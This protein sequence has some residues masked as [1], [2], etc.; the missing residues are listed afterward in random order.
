MDRGGDPQP[1]LLATLACDARVG[2]AILRAPMSSV[3]WIP[4]GLQASITVLAS[5]LCLAAAT[6]TVSEASGKSRLPCD[7]QAA[8]TVIAR[9][10]RVAPKIDGVLEEAVWSQA[11]VSER[12]ADLVSGDRTRL[13]TRVRLLWDDTHL[14]VG[15]TVEEPK[16]R[17][18]MTRHNDPIYYENDV[19][20]FIAGDNAYYEFEINARNT[21]YEVF[22][23]WES[24]YQSS[25][26]AARPEFAR[27]NLQPFNGVGF[28]T[29]PRGPRLGHFDWRFPGLRTAVHVDGTLNDDSDTDRGWSVEIALPWSGIRALFPEGKR[30]IPPRDGDLWAMDFSRFN[31]TKAPAPAKDSGGWAL[32]PHGVWDSHIPECFA[33]VRFVTSTAKPASPAKSGEK[34][35]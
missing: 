3:F 7:P 8:K 9:P 18:Q 10:T 22:F 34:R 15:Y 4:A 12:F 28:T 1:A 30:T 33:Q 29:H 31:T 11:V 14:Y 17:A 20:L 13:D 19:E 25:G 21:V 23:I 5:T 26:F 32:N 2:L 27:K 35:P 24:A 6:N 16:V